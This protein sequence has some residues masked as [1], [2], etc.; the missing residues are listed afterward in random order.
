MIRSHIHIVIQW[1][2]DKKKPSLL[3][4]LSTF[5]FAFTAFEKVFN[6]IGPDLYHS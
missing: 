5:G 1:I 6:L 3:E 2:N 4:F